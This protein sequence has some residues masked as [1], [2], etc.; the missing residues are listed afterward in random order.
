V[1]V[2]SPIYATRGRTRA[3]RFWLL[4]ALVAT[5]VV[6]VAALA[7]VGYAGSS[8]TLADGTT[9]SG[10]DVGGLS[11]SDA[12]A[13]LTAA[14]AKA[15]AK[16]IRFTAGGSTFPFDAKQ[17]AVEPD[18]SG[19]VA[20]AARANSGF[21]PVRGL[22]RL[23]TR[24]FGADVVPRLAV[25]EGALE[26]ALDRIATKVD[27]PSRSARLVVRRLRVEVVPG[28][29][30]EQLDREAAGAV[31]VHALGSLGRSGRQVS[32]PTRTRAPDVTARQ[33]AAPAAQA[34][35]AL[36]APVYLVGAQRR[37]RVPPR[38]MAT[39]LELPSDGSHALRIG[40][41]AA[42]EYFQSLAQRVDVPARDASFAVAGERVRVVP[43]RPGLE[44]NVPLTAERLLRAAGRERARVA[45]L[46]LAR[47]AP[48]ITT[49]RA[50]AMGIDTRMAGYKTFY[51]GTSDRVTNLRLGVQALD[52]TLV[53]PGGTFSLNDAIGERTVERGFRPAPVIVGTEYKEEVGGGTSQVATTVFNAAW[54]AGLRITERHPHSLYISRYPLG[55]D[56]TVYWPSLDLKFQNDTKSWVLVK[57]YTES[58]GIH[59]V[60]YGGERRRVESSAEPLDI[61]GPVPQEVVKD[62]TLPKGERVVETE[63]STP[64]RTSATRKIYRP[65]GTLLRSETWR[66]S[67]EGETRV[68]RL[69]TKVEKPKAPAKKKEKAQ[70]AATATGAGTTDAGTTTPS[71]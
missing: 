17:L 9:V 8:K 28:R 53:A 30:G 58:D 44:L 33:L 1:Q 32:L 38:R 2:D 31:I 56:A 45:H 40:G 50:L 48:E 20:A 15:E 23:R 43:A 37:W 6:V 57:G 69:G 70:P 67:Y 14:F 26:Y 3:S 65:D 21:G 62:P 13:A 66:T 42:N 47:S 49:A 7:L 24:F 36:S 29:T 55:R 27:R 25:S 16:P 52:D 11:R 60:I 64:S 41:A 34:R 10:V 39:L 71:S 68:V 19:A 35:R 51:A 61:T 46:A 5:A 54:E 59:V 18:W 12:T 22:R 63:G 4:A